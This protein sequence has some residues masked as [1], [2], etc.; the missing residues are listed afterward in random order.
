MEQELDSF[1]IDIQ[2]ITEI[3]ST[4]TLLN[5]IIPRFPPNYSS[6]RILE[7]IEKNKE[8]NKEKITRGSKEEK[9][10][11]NKKTK[12]RKIKTNGR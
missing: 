12:Q 6:M 4:E 1:E 7:D 2:G 8:N 11:R 5:Q 3:P 9:K 10:R